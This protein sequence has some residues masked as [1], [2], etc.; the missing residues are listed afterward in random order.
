M[1]KN[2]TF[3]N[4]YSFA[5][6]TVID[7]ALGKKP[8]PSGYDIEIGGERY[9]KAIAV[10]GANGSGKTQFLKP[11]AF[12]RWFVTESFLGIAPNRAIPF[13]PHQLRSDETSY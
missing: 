1:I 2:L 8:T 12:L 3:Q 13:F 5:E 6:Q 10:V 9:N 4:F 11:L 7:F